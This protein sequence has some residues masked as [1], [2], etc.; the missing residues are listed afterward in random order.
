MPLCPAPPLARATLTGALVALSLL[1]SACAR[2]PTASSAGGDGSGG[3]GVGGGAGGEGAGTPGFCTVASECGADTACRAWSCDGGQCS[4][5]FTAAGP[6]PLAL[7]SSGDCIELFCNG[8][9]SL[10]AMPDDG[11][12]PDDASDCSD[13]ACLMGTP[14]YNPEPAGTPC[15]VADGQC[16]GAGL[17]SDC[18]L[19]AD[20]PSSGV[21]WLT[22]CVAGQCMEA[23]HLDG[24]V[25]PSFE[26]MA[27]DC[28]TVQCDGF[29]NEVNA[30][31]DDD[32]PDSGNAC[33]TGSCSN[34]TP[35][36]A[37]EP[38]EFLCPAAQCTTPFQEA[39]FCNTGTCVACP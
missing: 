5:S 14:M 3:D 18:L 26:Q 24:Y 4:P 10:I 9:G 33:V 31:D 35:S 28:H 21:C 12:L 16:N 11:D 20:C 29:G 19:P 39:G 6:L 2:L 38:T 17:C 13:P 22:D 15:G 36:L 37:N 7:Q 30:V 32:T 34:G 1:A 8:E 23:P 27:G 25:D